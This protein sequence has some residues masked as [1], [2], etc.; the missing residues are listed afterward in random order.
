MLPKLPQDYARKKPNQFENKFGLIEVTYF[1]GDPHEQKL[2]EVP[3]FVAFYTAM[4]WGWG[5]LVS[6]VGAVHLSTVSYTYTSFDRH[7]FYEHKAEI[8][9]VAFVQASKMRNNESAGYGGS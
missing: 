7:M 9:P 6:G 8:T 4:K 1:L 3:L 5:I 2:F